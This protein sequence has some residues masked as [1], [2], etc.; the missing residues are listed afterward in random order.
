[1]VARNLQCANHVIFVSPL[2]ARSEYEYHSIMT[3]AVGRSHRARQQKPVHVHHFAAA[4]TIE[5][6]ILEKWNKK[7]MVMRNGDFILVSP[8]QILPGDIA[9]WSGPSLHG[10]VSGGMEQDF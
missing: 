4:R 9:D 6:N 1:M 7:V 5:V 3:Q 10:A 8:S 2:H